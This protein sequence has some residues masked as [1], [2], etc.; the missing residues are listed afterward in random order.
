MAATSTITRR[1]FKNPLRNHILG[2]LALSLPLPLIKVLVRGLAIVA[3]TVDSVTAILIQNYKWSIEEVL[4][5]NKDEVFR[6]FFLLC[7][8]RNVIIA[9]TE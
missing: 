4:L 2:Q 5:L 1:S 7:N 9:Q 6:R 8:N 3:S